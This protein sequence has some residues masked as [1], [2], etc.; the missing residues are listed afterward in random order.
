MHVW[1][2]IPI[3]AKSNISCYEN[4]FINRIS[5]SKPKAKDF[6][7]WVTH[8]VLPSIRKTGKYTTEDIQDRDEKIK[9]LIK[10]NDELK[11]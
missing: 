9:A 7:R 3:Y 8:E 6:K 5:F 2:E 10:I 1:G 4:K 11:N